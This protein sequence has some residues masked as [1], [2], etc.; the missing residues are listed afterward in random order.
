[1]KQTAFSF[2]DKYLKQEGP[3]I[4]SGLQALVR[5]PLD[6]HLADR[7]AGLNTAT[8]ISGYRGSPLAGFDMLLEGVGPLL[9]ENQVVFMPGVNEDLGATAVFGSQLANQFPSP[10]FD[11]VLGMWYGKAPGVD[12]SGDIF[13][14]ANFTGV[15]RYGGVLAIAGDDPVAKSSTLPSAS[16]SAFFA[17]QMPVLY[18]G[19]I[20][21]IIAFGRYGFELSRY[22]GL[23]VGFKVVTDIA[24]GFGTAVVHPIETIERPS[25][26]FNGRE[27]QHTQ[28]LRLVAPFSLQLEYELNEGR[29]EAARRFSAAN[30][31]NRI[32]VTSD[33]DWLGIVAAGKTY[34]DLREA[35]SL[36]GLNEAALQNYG[37]R[38]LKIGMLYPLEPVIVDTFSRGLQTL[39]VIEEKRAF[40]EMFIRDALYNQ[41]ERPMVIGKKD[42]YGQPLVRADAEL[43]ADAITRI[44]AQQLKGHLPEG[45]LEQRMAV[46][47]AASRPL[48]VPV[49]NT[50]PP[51]NRTPYFCSGCPH[52][53]STVVPE[54]SIA[55]GGIGCHGMVLTMNRNTQGITHMGGEGVQWVGAAPFSN[56]PH[57][58][59]NLGDGTLAHSGYMAI[60]QAIAA[61]TNITYKILYNDAVAM[62]GAQPADGGLPV[63]ELTRALYAEGVKGIIVCADDPNKYGRGTQW[64]PG[65]LIWKRERLEE[66]Q[67]KL[68]KQAGVSIIIYDQPCAADLRRQRKR[69]AAIDPPM[70]VFINEAVC[71]GCGD[72]GVKS[73]CLSVVPVDTEFGR[74]TQIHQAS[75]NK[76]YTCLE[77]DCPSFLTVIPSKASKPRLRLTVTIEADELPEPQRRIGE[78]A[79]IYMVGIGGTGVVTINQILGTAAFLEGKRVYN[80]DQTG[81]SQKGGPVLSHVKIISGERALSNKISNG[82]ADA[83][84][85]FDPLEAARDK[86]LAHAHV[87]RTVAIVSMSEV[88]TGAMIRSTVPSFPRMIF[89]KN[90]IDARTRKDDNVYLD[91]QTLA[92]NIF[93]SHLQ[94]NMI[95][96]GAAY[97]AGLIPLKA[98]TIEHVIEINGVAVKNNLL[99]FRVGRKV[100][101]EP[102]W[103][104]ENNLRRGGE[105]DIRPELSANAQH[106]INSVNAGEELHRLLE[107][108]VPELIAYQNVNYAR[109]YVEFVEKVRSAEA[110]FTTRTDLSEAAARYLFKLMAYKDEY[111]VARLHL[112][113]E[114]KH[115]LAE[116]F[117][118]GARIT[119][120]LHPPILRALGMKQKISLGRWFDAG[121]WLLKRL[122]FLRGTP[123]DIFG[124]DRVRRLERQ[125]ISEYRALIEQALTQLPNGGYE[126]AVELA[127]LPDL[128]R[129]YEHI[130]LANVE[131]F[132]AEI[133]RIANAPITTM[134]Q[135]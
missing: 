126:R 81:L 27:W 55:G 114:F 127:N 29:L 60:R 16:E 37:I 125:L 87:E 46:L 82:T 7:K 116:Q 8:F 44:L 89:L 86:N 134:V 129:G 45:L 133:S 128:I 85:A 63:P 68:R 12:R 43:S 95:C 90:S 42:Q 4:L 102:D 108:R 83:Y 62:T 40:L 49:I 84:I 1:M 33:N 24:D 64:A 71:E 120:K 67:E 50:T 66:A 113:P 3:I 101:A 115:A 118:K 25:F 109:Q 15:G 72:C 99:A 79:N 57:L 103:L 78:E 56:T 123:F 23:W 130:K 131:K 96:I 98:E 74:K 94:A 88:P 31:L 21:E 110:Q 91:A 92:E 13:K 119:Y 97:Q 80:L 77:G 19:S 111:E 47:D 61:G 30:G 48:Q 59:Q 22:S 36:L 93:G 70:R 10:K 100:V 124:Y 51:I 11:G 117:G 52:N 76:D 65:T 2:D 132:R 39:L 17:A 105:L 34:Y 107:I 54:G 20:Q 41:G 26:V 9:K 104:P 121:F 112:R 18:P 75:C 69:G 28:D 14:H 53:R 122:K 6:Q 32:T 5:I 35:L 135:P 73:N 106:L 38:L 58:F